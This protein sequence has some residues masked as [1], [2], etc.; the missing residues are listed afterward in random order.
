MP[1]DPTAMY[2]D[3]T[4]FVFKSKL[5]TFHEILNLAFCF[6]CEKESMVPGFLYDEKESMVPGFLYDEKESM[7]S[8][9]MLWYKDNVPT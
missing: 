1:N 3:D 4:F 7:V 8:T 5:E 2:I 9:W 6:T